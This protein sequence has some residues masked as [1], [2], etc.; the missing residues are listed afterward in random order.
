MRA[1]RAARVVHAAVDDLAVARRHAIANALG[2]LGDDDL[3]PLQRSRPRDRKPH[4]T[5][6]DDKNLHGQ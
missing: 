1:Q 6:A 3:V 4:H 5:G 2:D